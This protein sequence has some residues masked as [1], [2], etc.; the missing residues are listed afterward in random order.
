MA[1][2]W[3]VPE[4]IEM[5]IQQSGRVGRDRLPCYALLVY[6]SRDLNKKYTSEQMIKYCGNSENKCRRKLLFE[7]F[8]RYTEDSRCVGCKCCDV[9]QMYSKCGNCEQ[10][11]SEFHDH[12]IV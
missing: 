3:G 7:D 9:C 2:H 1:I 5:Y 11:I 10:V 8:A 6:G 4:D 12:Y